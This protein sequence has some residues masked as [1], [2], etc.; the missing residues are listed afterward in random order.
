M[1]TEKRAVS[2]T[3]CSGMSSIVIGFEINVS[4]L[5]IYVEQGV[6]DG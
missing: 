5:T 3:P 2:G 1:L 4:E 6:C